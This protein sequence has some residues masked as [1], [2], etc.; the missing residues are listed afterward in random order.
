LRKKQLITKANIIV[1]KINNLKIT[2]KIVIT[3]KIKEYL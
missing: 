2:N 1:V 3:A